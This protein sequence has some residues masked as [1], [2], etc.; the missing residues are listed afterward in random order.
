MKTPAKKP[1]ITSTPK[2]PA[3]QKPETD[4]DSTTN[5]PTQPD[6]ET[7]HKKSHKIGEPVKPIKNK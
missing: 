5:D 4:Y 1:D 2:K 6:T 7:E 3:P